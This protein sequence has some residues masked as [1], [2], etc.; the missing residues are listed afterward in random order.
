MQFVSRM[1]S[2]TLSFIKILFNRVF[3]ICVS[4]FDII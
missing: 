4:L 1:V 3:F 2:I